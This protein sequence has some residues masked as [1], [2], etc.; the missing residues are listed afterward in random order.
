[1]GRGIWQANTAKRAERLR[2]PGGALESVAASCMRLAEERSRRKTIPRERRSS[3]LGEAIE[4][5]KE[6][7]LGVCASGR[8]PTSPAR[9]TNAKINYASGTL[10]LLNTPR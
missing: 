3:G 8:A 4:P 2:G 1:M 9:E 7:F 6:G 5:Q 10:A